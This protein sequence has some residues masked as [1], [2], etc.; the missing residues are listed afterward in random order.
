MNNKKH[1]KTL[2]VDPSATAQDIKTA[3][4]KL[5][6]KYH[7][8]RNPN[9]TTAEETFKQIN[10]AYE[11][12]KDPQKR[13]EYDQQANS[14]SQQK[15]YSQYDQPVKPDKSSKLNNFYYFLTIS[16][17]AFSVLHVVYNFIYKGINLTYFII[18]IFNHNDFSKALPYMYGILTIGTISLYCYY[19]LAPPCKRAYLMQKFNNIIIVILLLFL[20]IILLRFDD[21]P[22]ERTYPRSNH[23]QHSSTPKKS[24]FTP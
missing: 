17:I 5:A 19:L 15:R 22:N 4:H 7:P 2:G 13:S 6:M 20:I 8:D 18:N 16:F 21:S 3:Y 10:A 11:V 14:Y 12:L 9:N 1:Y 24:P 23:S